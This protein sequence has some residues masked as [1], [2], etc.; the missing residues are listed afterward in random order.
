MAEASY[1][2]KISSL[3]KISSLWKAGIYRRVCVV[4]KND[5]LYL[6][7][8]STPLPFVST[9]LDAELLL[10][11]WSEISGGTLIETDPIFT[12]SEASLFANG[13]KAKLDSVQAALNL[14]EDKDNKKI[15]MTGNTGSNVFFLTAKA[16][17]DWGVSLFQPLLVSGTNLKTVENQSLLGSGNV[18]L[19]IWNLQGNTG[20]SELND[21]IGNI[22]DKR[23]NF[24]TNNNQAVVVDRARNLT[25]F[26]YGAGRLF[27]FAFGFNYATG[28]NNTAFGSNSLFVC[29]SG[30]N[31]V[32]VGDGAL[33][34][35]NG[36][37]NTIIGS[38]AVT[39][40]GN[41][42]G[43]VAVGFQAG[44]NHQG[45]NNIFL[46][47]NAGTGVLGIGQN[48][49]LIGVGANFVGGGFLDNQINIG[50]FLYKSSTGDFGIDIS[51]PTA[52]LDVNGSTRLRGSLLDFN[53][54]AGTSG[55]ILSST[56]AGVDWIDLNSRFI[57]KETPTGVIDGSNTVFALANI[58]VIGSEH[59]YR[60]GILSFVGDQYSISGGTITFVTAPVIGEKIMVSYRI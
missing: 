10:G 53:N 8:E 4:S 58:P 41:C 44:R 12:A 49:I 50:N 46:G 48:N 42:S 55:Q 1:N 2:E 16:I 52:K 22:D 35:S 37:E 38:L 24:R 56:V 43:V 36:S 39:D 27:N 13:D 45:S 15:T 31:N 25:F 9:D 7:N 60:G 3:T 6:L 5:K 19:P 18:D 17:Y 59:I 23:L 11:R 32:A 34:N 14:K 21:F 47:K 29:N 57:D 26:G 40:A 54:Q 30:S 33:Y 20:T 51:N 28:N